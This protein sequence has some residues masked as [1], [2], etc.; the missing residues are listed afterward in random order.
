MIHVHSLDELSLQAAWTTVGMFDGLHRGHQAIIAPM[1]RRAHTAGSPAV[2]ITFHPSPAVVL[3]G[4]KEA[5]YL[6]LPEERAALMGKMGV[7]YV[8][9]LE[10]TPQLA[11]LTAEEFIQWMVERLGM[12]RLW[13]GYDFALGRNR[14]GTLPVLQE[15]GKRFGYWVEMVPPVEFEEG[16]ISSSRIRALLGDGQLS[17]VMDLLGR[18]YSVHGRVVHGDG[19][20]RTLGIPT[21]NLLVPPEK[22]LPPN[23]VYA[24]WVWVE[25]QN[26]LPA[27]VNVGLR[28]TFEQEKPIRRVEAHVLDFE[29]DF[30]DQDVRLEFVNF[31]RPEQRFETPEALVTQVHQDIQRAR[32]ILVRMDLESGG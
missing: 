29:M 8:V 16:A 3:R 7:D 6:T 20:G 32:E 12:V 22:L 27:V 21:A 24:C 11:Q 23:G 26:C 14:Q 13:V 31:I 25:E 15:L 1:V 4:L 2:V 19:R 5:Q 30:Y 9:T 17:Q 28:P 10:F 18:W